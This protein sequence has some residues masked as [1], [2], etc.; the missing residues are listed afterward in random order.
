MLLPELLT[1]QTVSGGLV[2]IAD[3]DGCFL[4]EYLK[5]IADR[6]VELV[7]PVV[8]R[9]RSCPRKEQQLQEFVQVTLNPSMNLR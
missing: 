4:L 2:R 7:D 9:D 1:G 8:V 5:N 3:N 6:F